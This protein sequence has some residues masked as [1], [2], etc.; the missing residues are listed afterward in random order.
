MPAYDDLAFF[1]RR[2]LNLKTIPPGWI[3]KVDRKRPTVAEY[4]KQIKAALL[5]ESLKPNADAKYATLYNI[6]PEVDGAGNS[7]DTRWGHFL[8]TVLH[9]W[10]KENPRDEKQPKA[11]DAEGVV[12]SPAQASMQPSSTV[13]CSLL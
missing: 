12:R 4:V 3:T 5:K 10:L 1:V 7:V 2:K 13:L 9:P 6:I 8:D 11:I